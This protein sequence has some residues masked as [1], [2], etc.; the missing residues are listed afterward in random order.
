MA[1]YT[2]LTERE[3][4]EIVDDYGLVKVSAAKGIPSGSGKTNYLLETPRGKHLLRVDEVKGELDV[5]RELDLLLFLRKHGF[6][7]PQPVPDRKGRLYR[8][9]GGKCLSIYRWIDGHVPNPTRLHSVLL[10]AVGRVLADLHTIGKSYK[11]GIDNRFTFERIADTYGEVR[12]KLPSYFKRIVRT[13]DDEV[14]YL[15]SYLE[16][17]LPKGIIHGDL[18]HDN[19]LVK[20]D[21]IL[22]VLDFEAAC[23]GKFVYDLATAVNAFCFDGENYQLK[24]FEA[25]IA[26][27]ESLRALSLAE[28][29]AFPNELRF[30]ALRFTVT[31]LRDFFL[32][33]APEQTRVDKD[34]REFYERLRILRRE[35]DGGMEGL[36]MA[37]ATGYDYRKYQKVRAI[38]KKG[39]KS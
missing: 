26:G 33:P 21:K 17:K 15:R 28:W 4:S 18:F 36:L 19:L 9:S 14:D 13:L 2:Q 27:Y 24:R 35:R 23:R 5:K 22:A 29:D 7:C 3:I 20:G 11:K 12:G 32:N 25:L 39:T 1:V 6:P 37:M 16:T 30:S 8:E 38:E 31:R 10:E 34:F